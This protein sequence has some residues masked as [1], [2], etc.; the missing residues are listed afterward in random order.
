MIHYI[1][2]L[3]LNIKEKKLIRIEEEE[4]NRGIERNKCIEEL[5]AITSKMISMSCPIRQ[6]ENYCFESCIHFKKGRIS[7]WFYEGHYSCCVISPKCKL[8]GSE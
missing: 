7:E 3:I 4:R 6:D 5:S 2:Q 8:W 1:R